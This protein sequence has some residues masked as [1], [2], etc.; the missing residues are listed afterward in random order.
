MILNPSKPAL[1]SAEELF[2]QK[3][4]WLKQ[5]AG[6]IPETNF[7]TDY[8]RPLLST[9]EKKNIPLELPSDVSL[10]IIQVTNGSYLSIF[11]ILV[12]V[13][14]ILLQKYTGN[15]DIIVGSPIYNLQQSEA[16][17]N[18]IIPIRS[19]V[20]NQ[21]TCKDFLRQVQDTLIGA[22]SHQNYPFDELVKLLKMPVCRNR[23]PIFDVVILLENIHNY[24]C[25]LDV[26]NDL[27]FSFSVTGNS[28]TGKIEYNPSLFRDENIKYIA[29]YYVN[30][31]KSILH[32]PSQKISQISTQVIAKVELS[33]KM[34]F[35]TDSSLAVSNLEMY[36]T[37]TCVKTW[38]QSIMSAK[39]LFIF[40]NK[41][42]L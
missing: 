41:K 26:K 8:V 37:Q 38:F 2:S 40:P 4:Y 18:K 34:T 9:G 36:Q 10:R 11:L 3:I 30:I 17:I 25:L 21:L 15:H 39:Q 1:I 5:L 23:C 28:I 42:N 29:K 32:N 6:E 22:Y 19:Q 33:I 16:L 24:D 31:L 7:C 27:T 14:N 12:A 35:C 20:G 13:L